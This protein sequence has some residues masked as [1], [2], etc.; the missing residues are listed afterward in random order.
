MHKLCT[1]K[2]TMMAAVNTHDTLASEYLLWSWTCELLH[3]NCNRET[4]VA[5]VMTQWHGDYTNTSYKHAIVLELL[6]Q[7]QNNHKIVTNTFVHAKF[8]IIQLA[9][10]TVLQL[11]YVR[12]DYLL[13]YKS[14]ITT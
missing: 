7:S 6:S 4:I 8:I 12:G 9:F 1:M 5:I 3:G 2:N 11:F 10:G 13:P 14:K